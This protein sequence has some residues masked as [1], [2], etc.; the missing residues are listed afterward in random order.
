MWYIDTIEYY[1]SLKIKEIPSHVT[2]CMKLEDIILS[3]IDQL[4]EDETI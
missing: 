1:S 2:V 3:E 4:Q